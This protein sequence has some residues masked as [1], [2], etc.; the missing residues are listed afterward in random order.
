MSDAN[1]KI[2]KDRAE[3][4]LKAAGF[5]EDQINV[6]DEQWYFDCPASSKRHLC[7][8]GGLIQHS[9]N[10]CDNLIRMEVFQHEKSAYLVG[11]C[12][13]LVKL[14]NYKPL[15]ENGQIVGYKRVAA[16]YPGHGAASVQ[17][18]TEMGVAL[19]AEEMAAIT[20]HMGVFRL[21][22]DRMAEYDAAVKKFPRA[23]IL[24]HAADH[25]AAAMEGGSNG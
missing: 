7:C 5:T 12:H 24:T 9:M 18:A 21:D 14:D 2:L 17:I 8:P 22:D 15:V 19:T 20:W 1:Y 4:Y 16:P 6:L 3:V 10:V 11:M 13:D 23:I 25:L